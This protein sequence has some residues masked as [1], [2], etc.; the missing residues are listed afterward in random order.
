MI[1]KVIFAVMLFVSYSVFAV[2][3]MNLYKA[4]LTSLQQF[5]SIKQ[6]VVKN[7]LSS[8]GS[9]LKRVSQ[10]KQANQMIMR[11]QQLYK[12]IPVVGAQ[13]TL[14]RPVKPSVNP[15][16][17]TEVNGYLLDDIQ[18]D[19]KP[20]L[21]T[22]EA[23]EFAQKT[24][25]NGKS[26]A[27][28]YQKAVELQIR[29]GDNHQ[30]ELVYLVS[31]K[32]IIDGK[33]VW[34]HVVVSAQTGEIRKSWNNIKHYADTGAGGNDKTHE[35]WYGKDGLPSLE[36]SKEGDV[37]TFE[38]SKVKLIDLKSSEDMEYL[39][40][41]PVQYA[42]DHNEEPPTH[43]A[44]SPGNDA[45]YFGHIIVDMYKNWYA[46]P[47]L[48]DA[49]GQPLQLMM[50]VHFGKDYDNAFWDGVSMTFGDG[51]ELYPLV[52]L[53]V[54]GHEVS[55]G[56]TEQHSNLEYH[57]ESGALNE[58]FSD[59]G[60]QASRAYLLETEPALYNKAYLT[61]NALTWGI[62]ETITRAPM[63]GFRFMDFPTKDGESADCL[64]KTLAKM[65]G[66]ICSI[67]YPEL[68]TKANSD[69]FITMAGE[70]GRQS[71]IV[72]TASGIFNKVFYLL[73]K[74]LGIK[75][76]F[77]MMVVANTKYWL[78]NT[79]FT[80]GACG[81]MHAASDLKIDAEI[82]STVFNKVG[83]DLTWCNR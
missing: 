12:G 40:L 72:H 14:S 28:V 39:Q 62:G 65:S 7:V 71:Y 43:G 34:P 27:G 1:R 37:C 42:C 59:M 68:I 33:L 51:E 74:K 24:V 58:A 6:P 26:P 80:E 11:Y 8:K 46:I 4:P 47:A 41:S 45:Y 5:P 13:V 82:V 2:T 53:D 25:F 48:Q 70:E 49:V 20:T 22:V 30:M 54:A 35:Y 15:Y 9:D 21:T 57:D 66:G 52:S 83:I 64:N 3:P 55:H 31:F 23:L 81:V 36:V 50:R 79:G 60:G 38:D 76:A 17:D 29:A 75:K 73:S 56:F 77:Q 63:N 69:L 61:P 78:P 18:L 19:V 10:T 16:V 67:S 44:F 32:S